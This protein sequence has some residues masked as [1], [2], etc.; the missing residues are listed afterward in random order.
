M[1]R[2]GG[3]PS[4]GWLARWVRLLHAPGRFGVGVQHFPRRNKYLDTNPTPNHRPP[5]GGE[6]PNTKPTRPNHTTPERGLRGRPETAADQGNLGFW[7][8]FFPGLACRGGFVFV[9]S[10][11]GLALGSNISPVGISIW[12]PTQHQTK[13][14]P[15]EEGSPTPN[16]SGTNPTKKKAETAAKDP[17]LETH[18][19]TQP[20]KEGLRRR[21]E[22][23]ADPAQPWFLGWV[24]F[25]VGLAQWVRL[26]SGLVPGWFGVAA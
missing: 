23:A 18:H 16:Q 5:P 6:C 1:A 26:G 25:R 20:R 11:V 12:T 9:S 7:D 10:M 19:T 2:V 22:T 4:P 14:R 17:R 15:R 3:G 13:D 24:P 21:P 8:G